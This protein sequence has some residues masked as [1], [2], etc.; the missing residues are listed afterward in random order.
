MLVRSPTARA[1]WTVST[2][3]QQLKQRVP[4]TVRSPFTLRSVQQ[5]VAEQMILRTLRTNPWVDGES[6]GGAVRNDQ[7]SVD[8][9]S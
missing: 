8:T 5:V 3:V 6:V 7:W 1:R 2:T 9:E 4:P